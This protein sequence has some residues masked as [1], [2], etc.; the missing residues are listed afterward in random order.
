[1]NAIIRDRKISLELVNASRKCY[2]GMYKLWGNPGHLAQ[3]YEKLHWH[4]SR[5]GEM[6]KEEKEQS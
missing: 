2:K 4:I 6:E 1:M 3:Y 5:R